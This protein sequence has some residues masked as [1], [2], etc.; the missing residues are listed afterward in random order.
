MSKYNTRNLRAYI[1]KVI[2]DACKSE[3]RQNDVTFDAFVIDDTALFLLLHCKYLR[4]Q[5]RVYYRILNN[6]PKHFGLSLAYFYGMVDIP[7]PDYV[8]SDEYVEAG[9]TVAD[10][11]VGN[12]HYFPWASCIGSSVDRVHE[13]LR[14][15]DLD[16]CEK[17]KK[18]ME[19]V[20]GKQFYYDNLDTAFE[21][22]K[23][24]YKR[25]FGTE[26]ITVSVQRV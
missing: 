8:V 11:K 17:F 12:K 14:S 7:H 5:R 1:E 13:P 10:I 26:P 4:V 6:I 21:R 24:D 3:S 16:E 20:G 2:S 22:Y 15:G 23:A 25:A 19:S 9:Y 18:T